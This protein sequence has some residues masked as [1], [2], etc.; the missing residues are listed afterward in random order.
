M[1]GAQ[2]LIQELEAQ[3]VETI[4]GYPGGAIMPVYD[5]L[6]E[7]SLRH[8]LV[9]H[10]QAAALAAGG[11]AR[12]TGR[13]GVC[14]AT[15]GP[16][17]TNLIT[18]IADAFLDSV[19]LVA[20]T[21]QVPTPVLGTDAFQEV[22]IFSITMPVV[23]HSYLVRHSK[24]LRQVIREAFH[25]ANSGRPGPV[26]ID[27]PKDVAS[28]LS[29]E[30]ESTVE[31]CAQ[32]PEAPGPRTE[33][34]HHAAMMI[35]RSRRPVL[36]AGGGLLS[37][38]AVDAFRAY[39]AASQIPTV[40]SLNGI[41]TL[42]SEHPLLLGMLGMHGNQAANRAVQDADLL[43]CMG[44]RFDDRATGKLASFAP[45]AAVIHMDI[46]PAELGKLRRPTLALAGDLKKTLASLP[47]RPPACADWRRT[48]LRNTAKHS[49]RY[50][51]PGP[52]VYAPALIRELSSKD[53]GRW[54]ITCDVGQH[55]MWVAQHAHFAR[56]EQHISSGG[57]GT[58]GFGVPAAIG[59]KLARPDADVLAISGDGSFMMNLQEL[60]T[61]RRYQLDIKIMLLDN[62]GLG[63]VRQWQECF[64]DSRF[65]E[66]DLSDNP[67]FALVARSFG[68]PARRLDRAADCKE[69]LSWLDA[70]AGPALLHV[71]IDAA[72]NVWPLVPP[73]QSNSTMI[74]AVP[75]STNS[76]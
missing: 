50:D 30:P 7:S 57:L 6:T 34:L 22:D 24:D 56:P 5:A 27:L 52:G 53:P 55:Q 65:S 59:V 8:V 23:K 26:L 74:E 11:Y 20:I 31:T 54:T 4:F 16:G 64:F 17:A 10:E 35:A 43:I 14:M 51:A 62:S 76:K 1:N 49:A 37:S 39:V 25:I 15:S 21:G 61:I 32:A 44:A 48:C 73:N 58:M 33:D 63:L 72:A 41:G 70:Q 36:Y 28:A 45:M 9:R 42:P 40:T 2:V 71:C 46:D 68:I 75:C 18:G 3:G 66:V 67:D 47:M 29:P 19:P 12:A 13:T 60:A 69:A 38:Q